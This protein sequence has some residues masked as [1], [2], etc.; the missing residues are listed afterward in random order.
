[1]LVEDT[2]VTLKLKSTSLLFGLLSDTHINILARE[3]MITP[4]EEVFRRYDD[5]GRRVISYGLSSTG[6]DV[7][8]ANKIAFFKPNIEIDMVDP[9]DFPT[10]LM[11]EQQSED[12]FVVQP[13]SFVLGYSF[14]RF[15]MPTDVMG[16]CEGKSTYVRTGIHIP[17]TP[18]EPGWCGHLTIEIYNASPYPTKI[19][20]YEGIIQ[21]LFFRTQDTPMTNYAAR[22]G[23]YQNQG[24]EITYPRM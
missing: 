1:M 21:V 13:H 10:H 23:K 8:L 19:Y 3:G 15:S 17:V 20:P 4:F 7:R 16:L 5:K 9:K 24:A 11:M 12:F 14:E 18:L 22:H 6:Y 2:N